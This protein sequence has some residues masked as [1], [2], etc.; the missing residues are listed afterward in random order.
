MDD[1]FP[2]RVIY[3]DNHLL[4][5]D[6]PIGLATQGAPVGVESLFTLAQKYIK[7]KYNKP[8]AV[9][10]GVVTRL[11]LPVSGVVVFARTSKA[12]NRLNEQFKTHAVRK[13]YHAL[14]HGVL[15]EDQGELI[16]VICEDPNNH[17]LWVSA[18]NARVPVKFKP[19]E[20]RLK[21]RVLQ[22]FTANT[23]VEIELKTGR[24][25][26]IRLQF[27]HLGNPIVGDAKY[28]AK[29]YEGLGI[30]LHAA[31][32]TLVHPTTKE[33]VVFKSPRPNW[34]RFITY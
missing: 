16:N 32:L 11:D 12:A 14:L 15:S 30:C 4:T 2:F 1:I 28:G 33:T 29:Y 17:R 9:Y 21:Y 19:K 23:L 8:G 3:E 10:L 5:L 7:E 6:K 13:V 20:A 24:K 25:H 18:P 27:S 22:R 31:E 34:R 26:Q